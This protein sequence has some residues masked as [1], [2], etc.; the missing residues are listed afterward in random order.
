MSW[1]ALERK[2]QVK[3]E[4]ASN[5]STKQRWKEI[6]IASIMDP[7]GM[8]IAFLVG[9][10]KYLTA[11]DNFFGTSSYQTTEIPVDVICTKRLNIFRQLYVCGVIS[12]IFYS[13]IGNFE[14]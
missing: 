1:A 12:L 2:S 14:N 8:N 9:E 11:W 4:Q 5:Y 7:N 6:S 10:K 3:I 13:K